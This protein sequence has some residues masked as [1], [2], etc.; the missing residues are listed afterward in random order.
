MTFS[1]LI[2]AYNCEQTIA[3]TVA[4]VQRSGLYDHEIVI[5]NDGSTD[6]TASVLERL[7]T[8]YDNL[9]VLTQANGGVS[10][11]RNLG[12]DHARGDYLVFVDA[13]DR[14]EENAYAYAASCLERE[15][16]D[17]LLFGMRFEYY[18]KHRCYQTLDMIC[19][20]EG[21]LFASEAGAQTQHLFKQNYLSSACNK[22]IRREL[23]IRNGLRFSPAMVSME[24]ALFSMQCYLL[25]D[26][27]YL[28]P[29]ALYRYRLDDGDSRKNCQRLLRLGRM[30]EY[31]EHFSVLPPDFHGIVR[32]IYYTLL[33]QRVRTY[34]SIAPL[35]EET[36]DLRTSK[37]LP[38]IS[39]WT[40]CRALLAGQYRKILWDNRRRRLRH[41]LIVCYK[42]L[43]RKF[44]GK[45]RA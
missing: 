3:D 11:A 7:Q 33:Y 21:L 31:I 4:S 43:R 20:R 15:R 30:T 14:L 44:G 38:E 17:M 37:Y 8:K 39:G 45:R 34:R 27:M 13:D 16:P 26:K 40:L 25:C 28:I 36:A 1:V 22:F 32:D 2:P 23:V 10:S 35:R 18:Y 6:G 42:L 5:I 24:D 9:S 19:R 12:I 29:R 41:R